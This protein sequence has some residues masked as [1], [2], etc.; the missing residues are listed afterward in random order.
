[1]SKNMI[2]ENSNVL[3]LTNLCYYNNQNDIV[4]NC[5]KFVKCKDYTALIKHILEVI[6]KNINV[7]QTTGKKVDFNIIINGKDI[8]MNNLDYDFLKML[9]PFLEQQFPEKVKFIYVTNMP[10]L[11]N[12][13]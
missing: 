10:L 12:C 9:I 4:I 3:N 1:M 13:I 11:F 7:L 5:V 2:L 8:K 6:K